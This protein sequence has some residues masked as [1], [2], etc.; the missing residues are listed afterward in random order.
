MMSMDS[1]KMVDT[2]GNI[3]ILSKLQVRSN[4]TP[5]H[6]NAHTLG[7]SDDGSGVDGV[8]GLLANERPLLQGPPLRRGL[9]QEGGQGEALHPRPGKEEVPLGLQGLKRLEITEHRVCLK[10]FKLLS[11]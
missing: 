4:H 2:N 6:F 8:P 3:H 11:S 9:Q 5:N 10:E 1:V 7:E